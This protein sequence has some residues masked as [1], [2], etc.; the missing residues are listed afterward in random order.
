MRSPLNYLGGKSRLA[1]KIVALIPPDHVCYCEPFCGAGWVLFTKPP[2]KAE[3]INDADGE[4]VT[5][6]RV[7]QH[8]L[9]PFLDCFK[10]AVVSRKVFEWE[11]L[12]RP[13]TL[14]DIQRAVRY[15]YLQRL[16]FGGKP[17]GRTFGTAAT[18][19]SGLNLATVS[20]RL[21]EV[22]WRLERVTVEH[23]DAVDCIR[24]YDR[25]ETLFYC[26]PPYMGL[27]Q[28]YASK[29]AQA[30]FVRLRDC[31]AGIKGRFILSLND[32]AGVRD[33]FATFKIVQVSL[34]YSTGNPRSNA[35][36]RSKVRHEVL[37][38]NF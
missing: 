12:K 7:I 9:T 4:L 35:E 8:H 2:S 13:E 14:T 10:W 31:L 11:T 19:P 21:L 15:Y 37:I 33:L 20:E 6:W 32:C 1:S 29:F 27:C 38:R 23:L 5:F 36:S 24:R 28:D 26:D 16:S 18:A 17:A 3:V 25:P 30:D 22:H 34:R